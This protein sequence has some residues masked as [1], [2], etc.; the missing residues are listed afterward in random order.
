MTSLEAAARRALA[1]LNALIADTRDPGTEALAAQF[2]LEQVLIGS[3]PPHPSRDRWFVEILD[4][5]EWLPTSGFRTD[6][7]QVL[8]QFRMASERRP[9]WNNGTAV[10]RR[11]VRETTSYAIEQP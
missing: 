11:F 7:A 1:S 8:A 9:T 4:G 6:R 5:D 3:A 2:E 10:Q